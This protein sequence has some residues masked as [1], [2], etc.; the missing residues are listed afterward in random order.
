MTQTPEGR[1]IRVHQFKLDPELEY[2][3]M[4]DNI[5]PHIRNVTKSWRDLAN[6]FKKESNNNE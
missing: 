2:G 4:M 3:G 5:M 6:A 1:R